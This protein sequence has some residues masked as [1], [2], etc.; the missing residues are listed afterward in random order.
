[1]RLFVG[2]LI[3][4]DAKPR[5]IELQREISE[6]GIECKHV[7]KENLHINFSFLGESGA[8]E[9]EKIK[10]D[11][12]DIAKGFKKIEVSL[13]GVK[14]IPD[15]KF[16]RVLALDVSDSE[17][18]LLKIM[19]EIIQRIGGDVKPPHVTIC[20]IK[21]AKNKQQI[22]SFVDKYEHSDFGKM[23]IESIQLIESKL[24]SFG[25]EYSI[26]GESSLKD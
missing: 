11:L 1:M 2:Y 4:D 19:D 5:I 22:I 14:A 10:K 24:G 20:R 17:G 23:R 8:E 15:K 25:P 3:P 16:T 9:A 21:S 12:D 6:F 13:K 7:E 26:I 18:T